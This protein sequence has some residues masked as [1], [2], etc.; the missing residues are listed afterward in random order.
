LGPPEQPA[1]HLLRS[2]VNL[3]ARIC[4][5]NY[6]ALLQPSL[7]RQDQVNPS[8]RHGLD[9]IHRFVQ[10]F[11]YSMP[12]MWTA[13]INLRFGVRSFKPSKATNPDAS[14]RSRQNMPPFQS[15]TWPDCSRLRRW[16][17]RTIGGAT[18]R[19]VPYGPHG[20]RVCSTFF[21]LSGRTSVFPWEFDEDGAAT[22]FTVMLARRF[23]WR[24]L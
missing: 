5:Q 14:I 6:R 3:A 13:G 20:I 16:L 21:H 22:A 2:K 7:I 8:L 11:C 17:K 15:R 4:L 12:C 24:W 23:P 1:I 19:A 9:F 10:M 18:A